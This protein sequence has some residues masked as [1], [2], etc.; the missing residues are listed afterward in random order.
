MFNKHVILQCML[1][2]DIITLYF[3]TVYIFSLPY[4][5][6]CR[7]KASISIIPISGPRYCNLLHRL[8]YLHFYDLHISQHTPTH[9]FTTNPIFHSFS[10]SL[11]TPYATSKNVKPLHSSC[12]DQHTSSHCYSPHFLST[13]PYSI[14]DPFSLIFKSVSFL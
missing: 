14:N 7:L 13:F 1:V 11:S 10:Q 5:S 12:A 2:S 6:V 3:K 8:S 4:M 9:S